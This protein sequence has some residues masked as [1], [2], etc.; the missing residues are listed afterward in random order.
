MTLSRHNFPLNDIKM[1]RLRLFSRSGLL[2]FFILLTVSIISA[3]IYPPLLVSI[4]F[5]RQMQPYACFFSL[6][7]GLAMLASWFWLD[8]SIQKGKFAFAVVFT[9]L[10]IG[11]LSHQ[12]IIKTTAEFLHAQAPKEHVTLEII[13][14]SDWSSRSLYGF[15]CNISLMFDQ[16]RIAYF[17][18][19]ICMSVDKKWEYLA[20]KKHPMRL[21]AY[22]EKSYYGYE[23]KC[24]T[25]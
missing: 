14:S 23:L 11:F 3:F 6:Y 20:Y 15:K 4:E 24:C 10:V 19:S 21:T 16:P 8:K 25:K 2:L 7:T 12:T 18:Q 22:G 1:K 17:S 13:T 9:A 5:A